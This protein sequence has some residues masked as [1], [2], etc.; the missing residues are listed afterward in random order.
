A[1]RTSNTRS[2]TPNWRPTGSRTFGGIDD[3][4]AGSIATHGR[5]SRSK[6]TTRHVVEITRPLALASCAECAP[7][8]RSQCR[9][10]SSAG[11]A[12]VSRA[13]PVGSRKR[14]RLRRAFNDFTGSRREHGL[15][16][17]D[18][19]LDLLVRHLLYAVRVLHLHLARHQ[20][21]K[22]FNVHGRLIARDLFNC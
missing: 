22:Y 7:A 19:L 10:R 16:G 1:T 14:G 18:G 8:A 4:G 13:W 2:G 12:C 3:G 6:K 5:S 11:S 9:P 17:L 20:Q 15:N 21:R